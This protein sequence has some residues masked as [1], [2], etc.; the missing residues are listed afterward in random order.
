MKMVTET[1]MCEETMTTRLQAPNMA[2][3][4]HGGHG[5]LRKS[6]LS[7]MVTFAAKAHNPHSTAMKITVLVAYRFI[8]A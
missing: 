8:F 7:T 2:Y 5:P 1:A 3:L 6:G 4:F